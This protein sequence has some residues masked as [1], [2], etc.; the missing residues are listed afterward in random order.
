MELSEVPVW[1]G[2]YDIRHPGTP[3][4]SWD[5]DQLSS[6]TAKALHLE[7]SDIAHPTLPELSQLLDPGSLRC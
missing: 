1:S 2:H 7:T 5:S 6:H 4:Y 3:H